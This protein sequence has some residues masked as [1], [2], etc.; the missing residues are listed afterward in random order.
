[1]NDRKLRRLLPRCVRLTAPLPLA[2]LGSACGGTVVSADP[3]GASGAP[4]AGSG[5]S[6][7]SAGAIGVGGASAGN[8]GAGA[9]GGASAGSGTGG[10]GAPGGGGAS[11]GSGTGGAGGSAGSSACT[12]SLTGNFCGASR[13]ATVPK[14]C[15]DAALETVGTALPNETCSMV[16][17]NSGPVRLCTVAAV[18]ETSV[19]VLCSSLC[20]TGRRP[21]G[22]CAP[23]AFDGANLGSYFAAMARLEAGSVHAFRVLRDELR[24]HRAPKKLVAAAAR[25]ARDEIR[26]ARATDA[27][28]RRFGARPHVA[29]VLRGAL[30]SIEAMAIE[31]AVEG[32]V[33]ET[34]GAL[35][36]TWQ[37]R[38]ARDPVVRAA[39]M[40][41]ARDETRH[42]A[43]SWNVGQWLATRLD[44]RAQSRVE[45]AKQ[46]AARE[47]L[48]SFS[49]ELAP[50]FADL[51]GLPEPARASQLANELQRALWS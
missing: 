21:S 17:G 31:N 7:G 32:S 42:A 43:L 15:L 10:G 1:V 49:S 35:L 45:M 2:I 28:A 36:A 33:R 34:Y 3:G 41:I 9:Q 38:A 11:A 4:T 39:M 5:A 48:S 12:P 24:A 16:C 46:S 20:V 29:T 23:L 19:T 25:A 6:A 30:R 40:R 47:L 14:A 22:L 26:H 44:R 50:S 51:V 13:N 27:L 37:A 18:D 8:G